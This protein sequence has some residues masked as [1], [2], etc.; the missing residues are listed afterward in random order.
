L[1]P[2]TEFIMPVSLIRKITPIGTMLPEIGTKT[3]GDMRADTMLQ[4]IMLDALAKKSELI[5]GDYNPATGDLSGVIVR[6]CLANGTVEKKSFPT[7]NL[8]PDGTRKVLFADRVSVTIVAQPLEG[9]DPGPAGDLYTDGADLANRAANEDLFPLMHLGRHQ[10]TAVSLLD[11]SQWI[12]PKQNLQQFVREVD[13]TPTAND[14]VPNDA[15]DGSCYRIAADTG[16]TVNGVVVNASDIL[17]CRANTVGNEPAKFGI[18]QGKDSGR[19]KGVFLPSVGGDATYTTQLGTYV[20][21]GDLVYFKIDLHIALLGTGS[22]SVI[23]G[24]PFLSESAPAG[25]AN[26]SYFA[27]LAN[28]I[29]FVGGY[30]QANAQWVNIYSLLAGGNTTALNALFQDGSQVVLAG[31]YIAAS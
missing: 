4:A 5:A 7:F 14:D 17:I 29:V 30:I 1:E 24:L 3:Q 21:D 20:K 13:W 31:T 9:Q 22:T 23:Q 28:S 16:F 12:A 25:S 8:L 6:F 2:F 10:D 27:G 26:I 19:E 18:L 15:V 11:F